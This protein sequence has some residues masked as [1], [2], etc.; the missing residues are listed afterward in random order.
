MG[1]QPG[2]YWIIDPLC[3]W[4]YGALPLLNRVA[5]DFTQQHILPGGLFVRTQRRKLDANWLSHVHEHDARIA[6]LTGMTFGS[7]YR[8]KLLTNNEIVLDSL[9]S[10]RGLLAAQQFAAPGTDLQFLNAIQRAWYEKGH[11][12]TRADVVNA[13]LSQSAQTGVAL[14]QIPENEALDAI[15]H[16]RMLMAQTGGQ[17]FPSAVFISS[18]GQYRLLP[19]SRYYGQPEAFFALVSPLLTSLSH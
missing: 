2:L 3:G 13:V 4:S 14:G 17:G 5:Q 6:E 19:V 18:D 10:T 15:Q 7:D 12:I 11:D 1:F 8:T 9:P 16:G